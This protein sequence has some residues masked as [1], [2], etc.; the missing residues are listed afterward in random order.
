M[1]QTVLSEK[2]C[3]KKYLKRGMHAL[4]GQNEW[5]K[6]GYQIGK[7]IALHSRGWLAAEHIEVGARANCGVSISLAA[8]ASTVGLPRPPFLILVLAIR[9]RNEGVTIAKTEAV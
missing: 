8:P 7:L 3:A 2:E 5:P 6:I 9:V 1:A 4:F